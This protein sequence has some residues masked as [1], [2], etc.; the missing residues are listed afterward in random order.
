LQLEKASGKMCDIYV[1][2]YTLESGSRIFSEGFDTQIFPKLKYIREEGCTSDLV[3]FKGTL[4][5]GLIVFLHICVFFN[6]ST[7]FGCR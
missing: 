6:L 1:H 3:N 5:V 7:D 4:S 2:I